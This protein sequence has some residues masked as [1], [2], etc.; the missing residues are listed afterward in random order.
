MTAMIVNEAVL[1]RIPMILFLPLPR[2]ESAKAITEP[3]AAIRK[4]SKQIPARFSKYRPTAH[5]LK[6]A[7]RRHVVIPT[8]A[9][10]ATPAVAPNEPALVRKSSFVI[11]SFA[12][13]VN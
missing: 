3:I 7:S 6:L 8:A 11:L 2:L 4:M 10:N 1:D 13:L 5:V 9:N 12:S